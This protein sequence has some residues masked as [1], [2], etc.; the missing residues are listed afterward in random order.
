MR[1]VHE[2]RRH[3]GMKIDDNSLRNNPLFFL[4]ESL[5]KESKALAKRSG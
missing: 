5:F 1:I 2:L 4:S 3:N